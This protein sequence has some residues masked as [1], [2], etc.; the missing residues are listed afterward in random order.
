M[1]LSCKYCFW[2]RISEDAQTQHKV[3]N[4]SE[5]S[6]LVKKIAD[7]TTVED[8]WAIYQYL[9]KPDACI[10][11]IEISLFK[12]PIKPMWEDDGNKQGGKVTLKLKKDNT[13][14]IWEELVLAF[15]GN[16]LDPKVRDEVNGV[17]F[18]SKKDMN[19]IQIWYR[20]Y[21]TGF[22]SD[23]EQNLKE[24]LNTP[25]NYDFEPRQFFRQNPFQ[26]NLKK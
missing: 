15:V 26:K 11:G 20:N 1:N 10:N 25:E 24:L 17:I 22:I 3:L 18:S 8:F 2:Y 5:Y 16:S 23:L 4:Q 9:K 13:N 21:N 12:D 19:V 14:L 6:N 7:F